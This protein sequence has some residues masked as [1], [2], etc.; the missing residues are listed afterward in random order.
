M[1]NKKRSFN[2][3][4]FRTYSWLEYSVERD[5]AFCF[6]FRHFSMG[7]SRAEIAFTKY[8]FK[9]WKQATGKDGILQHHAICRTHTAAIQA[10]NDF[11]VNEGQGTY[12]ANRLDS[13]RKEQ[14]LR[15]RHYLKSV[16][17]VILLCSCLEIALRGHNELIG[18]LNR[19]NFVRYYKWLP[20]MTQLSRAFGTRATQCHIHLS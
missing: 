4:W 10:W 16:A 15:N 19:G 2:P 1:G 9:D 17:E 5:A 12:V 6:P 11:T 14:I 3:D 13:A 8:G 20:N 18:S 7:S